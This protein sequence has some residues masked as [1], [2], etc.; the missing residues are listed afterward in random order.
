MNYKTLSGILGVAVF[1]LLWMVLFDSGIS[2]Q[3][4]SSAPV[5]IPEIKELGQQIPA[6]FPA[7]FLPPQGAID[8]KYYTS[9]FE[10]NSD[11]SQIFFT[12]T[13]GLSSPLRA[14]PTVR[15]LFILFL[16]VTAVS[17]RKRD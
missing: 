16:E 10:G 3:G 17:G 6:G 15:F 14:R 7:E 1:V 2:F 11:L 12:G 5:S 4:R 8:L 13:I 9:K